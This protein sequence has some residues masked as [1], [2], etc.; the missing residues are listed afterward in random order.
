VLASLAADVFF[1]LRKTNTIG[2]GAYNFST[3]AVADA[4]HNFFIDLAEEH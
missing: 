2:H 1:K 4:S 3:D